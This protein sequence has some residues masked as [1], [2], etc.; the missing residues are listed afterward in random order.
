MALCTVCHTEQTRRVNGRCP[1]CKT[2]VEAHGGY[3][4]ETGTGSPNVALV[5]HFEK[6]L[7]EKQSK[8]KGA[9]VVFKFP[10]KSHSY[11]LELVAASQLLELADFDLKLSKDA[12]EVLFTDNQFSWKNRTTLRWV[13]DDFALALSLLRAT[14]E[15][16]AKKSAV[17]DDYYRRLMEEE[18]IFS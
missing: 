13:K 10:R 15:Q 7:S 3:W 2:R 16:L 4:F 6:L 11:K 1:N 12:L 14:L 5:E 9:T 17:E 8:I 18:D